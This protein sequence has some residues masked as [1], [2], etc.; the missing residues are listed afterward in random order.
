MNNINYLNKAM[1]K[2]DGRQKRLKVTAVMAFLCCL[3][4]IAQLVTAH[5]TAATRAIEQTGVWVPNEISLISS[6]INGHEI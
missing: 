6:R 5:A 2:L 4:I 1:L 3:L